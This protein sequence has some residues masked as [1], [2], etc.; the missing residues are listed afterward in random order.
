MKLHFAKYLPVEGEIK[1]G[2]KF[3]LNNKHPA[4]ELRTCY[5]IEDDRLYID[6]KED[7]GWGFAY[8]NEAKLTK[9]FLCSRDI[10]VGDKTNNGIIKEVTKNEG[11]NP[12]EIKLLKYGVFF[13]YVFEQ[14]GLGT[15]KNTFKI[16]GEISPDATWVKEG[17]E[18]D[19]DEIE[20]IYKK[21]FECLCEKPNMYRSEEQA[22]C[23]YMV[24][25][26]RGGDLCIRRIDVLDYIK[27]KGP[28]GHFH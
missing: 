10:Q 22:N 15:N 27:L 20:K 11:T 3:L 4:G 5:W 2:D 1:E 16:I 6:K 17:D 24:D 19:E 28:C 7:R 25:D 8:R 14:G 26:H 21:Q 18:F 23:E 12:D 13:W 9:L